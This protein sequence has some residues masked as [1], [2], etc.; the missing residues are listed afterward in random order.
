MK[1]M[2]DRTIIEP[3]GFDPRINF[4]D[5]IFS[6]GSCF[7]ESIGGLL[8]KRLW[9][10]QVNPLGLT[11]NP[12]S[13]FKLLDQILHGEEFTEE[14]WWEDRELW[15]HYDLHSSMSNYTRE[16]ALRKVN[17]VMARAHEHLNGAQWLMITLGTA[18]VYR[19]KLDQQIVNNCHKQPADRFEQDLMS[20]EDVLYAAR[21]VIR[22]LQARLPDLRIILTVSPVRHTRLGLVNNMRSKTIL[23]Q[24]VHDLVQENDH[25]HYF[26]SF[27]IIMDDLRSYRYFGDDLIHPN[28]QAIAYIWDYFREHV[29][30]EEA[31]FSA[32]EAEGLV[33]R[34]LH[35]PFFPETEQHKEFLIR[36]EEMVEDFRGRFPGV[37]W[38]PGE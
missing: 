29:L 12:H 31:R 25:I 34:Y 6:Q 16:K 26:P 14:G 19:L 38:P 33:H 7:A 37:V 18:W 32:K 9:N 30:T 28:S 23:H 5:K 35:H 22:N 10:I 27:E 8:K 20:K 17:K 3:L 21:P 11:Y 1:D 36:T 4:T 13:T 2:R 24:A 15:H